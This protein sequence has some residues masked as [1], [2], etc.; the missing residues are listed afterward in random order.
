[1]V[2]LAFVLSREAFAIVLVPLYCKTESVI[3]HQQLRLSMVVLSARKL[4]CFVLSSVCRLSVACR[5]VP[6]W[7]MEVSQVAFSLADSNRSSFAVAARNM[8]SGFC[9][10]FAIRQLC[11]TVKKMMNTVSPFL[12]SSCS[13]KT[14]EAQRCSARS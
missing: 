11:S 3:H 6:W 8:C 9:Y 7:M 4:S 12:D 14:M 13:A 5:V 1:L 10:G 2:Y